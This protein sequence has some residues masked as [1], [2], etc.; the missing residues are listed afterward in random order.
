M[1]AHFSILWLHMCCLKKTYWK[2]KHLAAIVHQGCILFVSPYLWGMC[3]AGQSST[4]E[5]HPAQ[6]I[7]MRM[8]W[9]LVM[10]NW[11]TAVV[12]STQHILKPNLKILFQSYFQKMMHIAGWCCWKLPFANLCDLK[13]AAIRQNIWRISRGM[14]VKFLME[15]KREHS[16]PATEWQDPDWRGQLVAMWKNWININT[17][18]VAIVAVSIWQSCSCQRWWATRLNQCRSGGGNSAAHDLIIAKRLGFSDFR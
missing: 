3:Q 6:V 8:N 13:T 7:C 17:N 10:L 4:R 1:L 9:K 18:S 12:F 16:A 14:C 2:S 5:E 15:L 11:Q